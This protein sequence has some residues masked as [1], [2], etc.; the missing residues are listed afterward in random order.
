MGEETLC[1]C[2][3]RALQNMGVGMWCEAC[4]MPCPKCGCA[5]TDEAVYMRMNLGPGDGLM[6][7]KPWD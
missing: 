2:G 5:M 7:W 3:R 4:A 6:R 1:H